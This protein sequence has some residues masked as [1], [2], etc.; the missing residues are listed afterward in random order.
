MTK[1]KHHDCIVAW[2]NGALI[3]YLSPTKGEGWVDC[4]GNEPAWSR[5]A[6]YRVKPKEISNGEAAYNAYY[7]NVTKQEWDQLPAT[8][9]GEWNKVAQAVIDNERKRNA[10]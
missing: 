4:M 5:S 8:F 7:H 9:S 1:H 10:N 6:T 2:A 3:Q